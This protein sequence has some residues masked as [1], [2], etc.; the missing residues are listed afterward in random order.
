LP[1]INISIL[2]PENTAPDVATPHITNQPNMIPH[3]A[4][5]IVLGKQTSF[6]SVLQ[7]NKQIQEE[8]VCQRDN[9]GCGKGGP[10]S[11]MQWPHMQ[12]ALPA[13]QQVNQLVSEPTNSLIMMQQQQQVQQIQRQ[14]NI[15]PQQQMILNNQQNLIQVPHQLLQQLQKIWHA[16]HNSSPKQQQH[17]REILNRM[18]QPLVY[19]NRLKQQMQKL[20]TQQ[21]KSRTITVKEEQEESTHEHDNGGYEKDGSQPQMKQL[22]M[23]IA[24]PASQVNQLVSESTNSLMMIQQVQKQMNKQA[25]QQMTLIKRTIIE[26]PYKL[27]PNL[28]KELEALDNSLPEYRQLTRH[29]LWHELQSL[30]R[31]GKLKQEK[32]LKSTTITVKKQREESTHKHDNGGYGKDSF[33]PQMKRLRMQIVP[34]VPQVNQLVSEPTNSPMMIQQQQQVQE[35]Q[36]KQLN[37]Q[38]QQQ[39]ICIK[40]QNIIRVPDQ[41]L[42]KSQKVLKASDN[43]S[44]E[45]QQ[46]MRKILKRKLKSTTTVQKEQKEST[47]EHDNGGYEKDG[48]QLQM[49]QPR[50]QIISPVPQV[51][52]LVSEPT[53]SPI[54]MQVQE[55]QQKQMNK[56]PQQQMIPI[57]RTIIQMPYKLFQNIQKELEASDNISSEHQ[58]YMRK[59]LKCKHKST[60]FKKEQKELTHEHDNGGYGKDGSQLQMKGLRMQIAPPAP[61]GNQLVSEPK[62][63]LMIM[64][65]QQNQTTIQPQQQMMLKNQQN[66]NEEVPNQSS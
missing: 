62:N 4:P 28:Q 25:Q 24:S 8:A 1:K 2:E 15:Q 31:V 53:N 3:K 29:I 57:K 23:Q 44:P 64:Q 39:I 32:L 48:S 54:M 7:V 10:Q 43:R 36:Q 18:L 22:R 17:I 40:K 38:P 37:K 19:L 65:Q 30:A 55:Q 5:A 52:Q 47:Q 60:T 12:I 45:H 6:T 27:F 51:N 46:Y 13:P 61:Q 14:M 50:M 58:E 35:Q 34:P 21:L 33:Q 16:K 9:V 49:K 59:I 42:Q 56:Q 11:Q 41:I 63:S 20:R 26:M 66:S